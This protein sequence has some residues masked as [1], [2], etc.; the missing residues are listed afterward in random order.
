MRT[1]T[2]GALGG[3][4]NENN[5]SL[6]DGGIWAFRFTG[7]ATD[8]ILVNFV[9]HLLFLLNGNAIR[10]FAGRLSLSYYAIF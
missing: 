5:P 8:A 6:F 2:F 3:V 7:S 4:D 10:T 9:G 1:H